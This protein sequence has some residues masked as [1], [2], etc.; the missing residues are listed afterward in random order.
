[1]NAKLVNVESALTSARAALEIHAAPGSP[2]TAPSS[3]TCATPSTCSPPPGTSDVQR[4]RLAEVALGTTA[5][6]GRVAWE[7]FEIDSGRLL[8]AA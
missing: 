8:Q 2:P 1:M 6:T 4:L 3:G 5:A 7:S